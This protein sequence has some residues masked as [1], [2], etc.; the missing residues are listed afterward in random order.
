MDEKLKDLLK[1]LSELIY[2]QFIKDLNN[3][4]LKNEVRTDKQ[5]VGKSAK[6]AKTFHQT[7]FNYK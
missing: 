6:K 4:N 7:A 2:D 1:K 5:A 3:G